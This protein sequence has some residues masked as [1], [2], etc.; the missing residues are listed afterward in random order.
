VIADTAYRQN[1]ISTGLCHNLREKAV[2]KNVT[3]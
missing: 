3:L 2:E 1:G